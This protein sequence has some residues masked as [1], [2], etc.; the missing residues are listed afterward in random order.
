M[1]SIY[2]NLKSLNDIPGILIKM[3]YLDYKL[4]VF[5]KY[6]YVFIVWLNQDETLYP[7]GRGG[8]TI[9]HVISMKCSCQ[10]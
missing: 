8:G 4:S 6:M 1:L 10:N 7:V 9:M 3:S 2:A 5:V